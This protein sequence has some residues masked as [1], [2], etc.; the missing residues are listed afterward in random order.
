MPK[1]AFSSGLWTIDE[2]KPLP[3]QD[4][5]YNRLFFTVDLIHTKDTKNIENS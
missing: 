1:F 4:S 5:T 2:I 3:F